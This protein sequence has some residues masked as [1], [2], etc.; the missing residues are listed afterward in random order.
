MDTK[1]TSESRWILGGRF[2]HDQVTSEMMMPGPDGKM[3]T[4][5]FEGAGLTGYDNFRKC[6]VGTWADS[7]G[8]Q[9][10]TMRGAYDP[11]KKTLT[12]YGEMDEPAM[13]QVGKM[14]R[15]VTRIVDDNTHI[16]EI[17]DLASGEGYKVMEITYTRK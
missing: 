17:Y 7:M 4:M 9:L 6:Y 2:L 10:L 15:Y 13:D 12:M 5:K 16:F 3:M 8:T 11:A 1:G 14:V